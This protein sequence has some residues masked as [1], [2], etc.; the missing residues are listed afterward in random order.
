MSEATAAPEVLLDADAVAAAVDALA[1]RIAPE[2]DDE[3]VVVC[4]LLGAVWFA[5]D[6]MRALA[7]RGRQ[8]LFDALWL[9]SYGDARTSQGATELRAS[10][11]RPVDGRAVLIV[12]DVLDSGLS[13][14]DACRRVWDS[15][16][17]SVRTAVFARKPWPD[18]GRIM[19]DFVGW[20]A[21]GRFLAG[22][23]MDDAGRLRG[24]PWIVAL[25]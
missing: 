13:L 6:L 22:Y 7:R 3:T 11:Q 8:P 16:A 5:A 4:L 9:G 23:G 21:P 20:E 12:D 17:G 18:P 19:P 2:I 25:D 15:G 24:L 10:L 14:A 1:S